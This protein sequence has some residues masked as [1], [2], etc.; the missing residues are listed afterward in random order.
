[1][2]AMRQ[3]PKI[4]GAAV[5][6]IAWLLLASFLRIFAIAALIVIPLSY[7]L[8][9]SW[10]QSFQYR[11]SLGPGIYGLGLALILLV[12][13]LT[14]GFETIKAAVMNPVNALRRE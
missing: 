12:T 6:Q 2:T 9:N 5:R 13:V 10:L 14:V 11:V 1:M 7:Y 3:R 4:H 8:L